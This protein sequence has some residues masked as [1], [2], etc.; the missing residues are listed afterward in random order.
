MDN[1]FPRIKRL[2]EYVFAITNKLKV[3]AR[4]RGE[5]IIDFD[6]CNILHANFYQLP[7][8]RISISALGRPN[9]VLHAHVAE[10]SLCSL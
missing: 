5:D 7:D 3:E 2:P 10:S 8:E 1:D 4:A 9:C 6:F